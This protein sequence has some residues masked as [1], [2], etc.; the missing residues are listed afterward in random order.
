MDLGRPGIRNWKPLSEANHRLLTRDGW[1]GLPEDYTAAC[2]RVG[3]KRAAPDLILKVSQP[4]RQPSIPPRRRSFVAIDDAS[5]G[6]DLAALPLPLV[7][8]DLASPIDGVLDA[9]ARRIAFDVGL[10]M[11]EP[12][13]SWDLHAPGL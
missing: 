10:P 8:T 5:V 13:P 2:R 1:G 12:I 3:G 6:P 9:G 11:P 7:S 4:W